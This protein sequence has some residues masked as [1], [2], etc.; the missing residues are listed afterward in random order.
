MYFSPAA[1]SEMEMEGDIDLRYSGPSPPPHG[2]RISV[3]AFVHP[4]DVMSASPPAFG[5]PVPFPRRQGSSSP[6][7]L[8]GD[9]DEDLGSE[10]G[11]SD[12][13]E[14][15]DGPDGDND[16]DFLSNRTS[17][18]GTRSRRTT[19]RSV[20][21]SSDS[22]SVGRA[23]PCHLSAAVPVPNLTKKSR[24]RRV[25]TAPVFMVQGGVQKNMRMYKCMVDG[26]NKCFARGE[27]LK[28]HVR[29][30]HSNEKREFVSFLFVRASG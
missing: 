2:L 12:T 9:S 3:P 29:K 25:P 13:A 24:G 21:V 28:R 17:H 8:T 27:H 26:C 20:S 7:G 14:I 5:A 18:S 22:G 19:G 30:I 4:S 23:R 15:S 10:S 6:P 16:G 11:E 1:K